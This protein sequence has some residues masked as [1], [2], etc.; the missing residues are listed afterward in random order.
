MLRWYPFKVY[1]NMLSAWYLYTII[2]MYNHSNK[3]VNLQLWKPA[4]M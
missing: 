4:G 1:T 3:L 2:P